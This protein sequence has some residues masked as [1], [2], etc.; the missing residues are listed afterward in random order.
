M[1]ELSETLSLSLE[2]IVN[3]AIK[4]TLFYLQTKNIALTDIKGYPKRLGSCQIK[5]NLTGKTSSRIKKFNM[6][7][8]VTECAIIGINLLYKKLLQVNS[9]KPKLADGKDE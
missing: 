9:K 6:A 8:Q 2:T 5:V 7:E 4:Y 3:L 1:L